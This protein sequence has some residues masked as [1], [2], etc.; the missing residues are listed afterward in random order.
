[1]DKRGGARLVPAASEA[2][3]FIELEFFAMRVL[4]TNG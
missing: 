2:L 4:P 3:P 1:M